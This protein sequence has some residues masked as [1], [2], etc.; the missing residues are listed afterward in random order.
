MPSLGRNLKNPKELR[1][2]YNSKKKM[3]A[4]SLDANQSSGFIGAP[5]ADVESFTKAIKS[6]EG[7]ENS[8]EVFIPNVQKFV[9]DP[10]GVP[11][12]NSA[13]LSVALTSA[14][15]IMTRVSLAKLPQGDIETLTEYKNRMDA[16]TQSLTALRDDVVR[17]IGRRPPGLSPFAKLETGL[18]ELAQRLAN[19]SQT[20]TNQINVYNSG[21]FQPV[22]VG[23]GFNPDSEM[24]QTPEYVLPQRFR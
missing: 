16:Y 22:K 1:G 3:Y 8:M 23:S 4:M 12:P 10:K 9:D 13:E 14:Q 21:V 19:L 18:E 20:I 6:F 5:L 2:E 24:Y 15:R 11:V 17:A 7:V